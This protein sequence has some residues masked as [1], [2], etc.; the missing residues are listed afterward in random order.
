MRRA[1]GVILLGALLGGLIGGVAA[2]LL[3]RQRPTSS[4]DEETRAESVP[5]RDFLKLG[6]LVLSILRKIA[7]R[8]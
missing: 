4:G 1:K 2:I 8:E 3:L 5:W 7:T 6:A